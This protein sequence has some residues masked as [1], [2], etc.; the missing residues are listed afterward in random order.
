MFSIEKVEVHTV[1]LNEESSTEESHVGGEAGGDLVAGV[2]DCHSSPSPLL[3]LLI[4]IVAACSVGPQLVVCG[5]GTYLG[6][7]E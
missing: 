3:I 5:H 6:L 2:E 7:G 4:K 1:G